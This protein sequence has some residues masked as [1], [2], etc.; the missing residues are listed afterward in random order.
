[1][2][3]HLIFTR[4]QVGMQVDQAGCRQTSRIILDNLLPERFEKFRITRSVLVL[5]MIPE[6]CVVKYHR[7]TKS[8]SDCII[9]S[10]CKIRHST[11]ISSS[12]ET[13]ITIK[14]NIAVR[15]KIDTA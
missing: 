12:D 8:D 7:V 14:G 13:R 2:L 15:K 3:S 5:G 1:M 4:Y 6:L 11:G 10:E 9:K